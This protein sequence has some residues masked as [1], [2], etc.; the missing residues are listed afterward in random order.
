MKK[1]LTFLFILTVSLISCEKDELDFEKELKDGF[2]IVVN[3]RVVLSYDDFEYY[4]YSTHLIY[5]KDNKSFVDDIES[6]GEFKVFADKKEIYVGQTVPG[7]HS[8]L[9]SGPI[10]STHPSGY[11][12]YI[13][14]IELIQIIDTL[15]NVTPDLREDERIINAL[16]SFNQFHAGLSCEI[17]SIQY[18]SPND[19][20]VELNLKNNDSFSYY[21]LDPDKMG[22]NLFHYFTNGLFI[23]DFSTHKSYTHKIETVS[24]DPWNTWKKDWLSIINGNENKV[25]TI[26]YD[27][28]EDVPKGQYKATFEFP[29]LSFQVDKNDI[30]QNNGQIWLGEINMIKDITIE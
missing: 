15:G 22:I 14:P 26:I 2:C 25:V 1:T 11:G 23:T 8:F 6:I 12:D 24:A 4:D 27:N 30:K 5:L 13:I 28:F 17:N 29:G 7:F 3:D 20:S 21:Y 16:K 9:P 18:L 19:V 10:I